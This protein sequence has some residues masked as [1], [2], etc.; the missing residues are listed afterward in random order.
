ML[1]LITTYLSILI[2]TRLNILAVLAITSTDIQKSHKSSLSSQSILIWKKRK[3]EINFLKLY[4]ER[5]KLKKPEIT[6]NF[7]FAKRAPLLKKSKF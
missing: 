5:R 3:L 4:F 7:A 6:L 2:A 1:L